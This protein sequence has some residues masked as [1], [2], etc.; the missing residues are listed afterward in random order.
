MKRSAR[1]LVAVIAV[2]GGVTP[3]IADFNETHIF[4]P[5]WPPHAVFHDGQVLVFTSVASLFAGLFLARRRGDEWTNFLTAYALTALYWI[6]LTGAAL[7]PRSA[8]LDPELVTD[9][10]QYIFG[11]PGNA[12]ACVVVNALLLLVGFMGWRGHTVAENP[13]TN[14]A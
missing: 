4:N 1:I 2:F 3:W 6:S 12:F 10:S 5:R 11:V 13:R 14:N 7:F 9:P 8:W